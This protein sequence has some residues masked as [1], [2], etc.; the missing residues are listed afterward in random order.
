MTRREVSCSQPLP[1]RADCSGGSVVCGWL[2]GQRDLLI[3]IHNIIIAHVDMIRREEYVSPKYLQI[4]ALE[5]LVFIYKIAR[6]RSKKSLYLL[7]P[8]SNFLPA[9]S[10]GRVTPQLPARS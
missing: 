7:T 10:L 9:D 5:V 3:I 6:S 8:T 2:E 4:N 1:G